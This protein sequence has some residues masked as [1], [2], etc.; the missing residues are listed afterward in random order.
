MINDEY[1]AKLK[2]RAQSFL[3]SGDRVRYLFVAREGNPYRVW[4][5]RKT[6]HWVV[7]VTDTEF[8][9]IATARGRLDKLEKVTHRTPRTVLAPE[10]KHYAQVDLDTGQPLFVGG[11]FF[12]EIREQ[13]AELANG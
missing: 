11:I 6:T 10:G 5:V 1:R 8:V 9:V 12:D 2:L 7:A 13:D 3:P 4:N